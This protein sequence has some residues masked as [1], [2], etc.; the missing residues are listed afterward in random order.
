M[1][2]H[3]FGILE[4]APGRQ[5]I[6]VHGS[7]D[8]D[9]EAGQ[10]RLQAIFQ[11][12]RGVYPDAP[13]FHGIVSR[14]TETFP[15]VRCYR[16]AGPGDEPEN[17]VTGMYAFKSK[18]LGYTKKTPLLHLLVPCEHGKY[19]QWKKK[20][21]PVSRVRLQPSNIPDSHITLGS[22]ADANCVVM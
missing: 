16:E 8:K 4:F 6:Q 22:A 3:R 14:G 21:V 19:E 15:M 10:E 20:S 13:L 18:P 2:N 5:F 1:P 9:F 11:L 12:L 17:I 7:K